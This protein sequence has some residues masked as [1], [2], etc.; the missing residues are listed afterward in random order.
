MSDVCSFHSHLWLNSQS[1]TCD[2][3]TQF[4]CF[5]K[6]MWK[7]TCHTHT[8]NTLS[9]DASISNECSEW[10]KKKVAKKKE[11]LQS[12]GIYGR[13]GKGTAQRAN[14]ENKERK[15]DACTRRLDLRSMI[16]QRVFL[17]RNG[18]HYLD[19]N[20]EYHYRVCSCSMSF[21]YMNVVHQQ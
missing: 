18:S 7:F 21:S 19:R 20:D 8:H 10:E 5:A 12:C 1:T 4:P 11:S 3:C 14:T 16:I 13:M 6:I 9:N 17:P 2:N 15:E